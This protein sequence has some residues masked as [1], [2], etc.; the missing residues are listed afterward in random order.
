MSILFTPGQIMAAL[1]LSKQQW[2]TY[3]QAL[4]SL[5]AE[6]R[7]SACFSAGDLLATAVVQFATASLQMP[8]SGFSSVAGELFEVC[9]AYPW[10]RLERSHLALIVDDGRV[11]LLDLDQRL[12]AC[13]LAIV[14]QLQ[15]LVDSLRERLLATAS[16]PQQSLA[17]PP[18]VAGARS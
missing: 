9:G 7:R 6:G 5:N 4:P 16:N 18:M 14:I 11:V 8:V 2:R 3:R 15:P 17:F 1:S 10:I 13:G 12:P